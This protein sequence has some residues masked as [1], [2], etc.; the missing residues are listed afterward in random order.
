MPPDQLPTGRAGKNTASERG[1]CWGQGMEGRE[2]V[3]GGRAGSTSKLAA[4]TTVRSSTQ[5]PPCKQPHGQSHP[6]PAGS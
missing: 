5:R 2:V 3:L 1:V 4:S 6:T